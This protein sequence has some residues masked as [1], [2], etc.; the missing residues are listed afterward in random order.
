M[1]IKIQNYNR[2][3]RMINPLNAKLNPIC[4]FLALLGPHPILHVSRIRVKEVFKTNNF[5]AH[6]HENL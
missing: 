3:L 4:H 1:Q 2:A 5:K 6:E